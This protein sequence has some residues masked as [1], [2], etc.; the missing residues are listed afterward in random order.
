LDELDL[1]VAEV[2]IKL[3]AFIGVLYL[4]SHIVALGWFWIPAASW[5]LSIIFQLF[6]LYP[7]REKRKAARAEMNEK[8]TV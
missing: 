1:I 5:L 3:C 4:G 7:L 6:V 2:H 8:A